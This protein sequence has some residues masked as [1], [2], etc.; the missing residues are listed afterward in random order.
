M[1][2]PSVSGQTAT[3]GQEPA[4]SNLFRQAMARFPATVTVITTGQGDSRRGLTATAVSSLSTEPPRLLVCINRNAEAHDFIRLH[5]AFCVNVLAVGQKDVAER[6]AAMDRSKG[7]SRFHQ[8]S[9]SE[10]ITGSPNLDGGVANVDCRVHQ[11][12]DAGSHTIII[13]DVVDV[14]VFED[15]TPLLYHDRKFR[16]L[17]DLA[18]P[19][20]SASTAG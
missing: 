17:G 19:S 9:W 1:S 20:P 3:T 5:G 11:M 15:N 14:R 12:I 13:G 2:Q 10:L 16:Q 4:L 6:F 7:V 8:G 18:S